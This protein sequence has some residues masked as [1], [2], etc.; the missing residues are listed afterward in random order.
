[1]LMA[2]RIV[3][4]L[5]TVLM[6][7]PSTRLVVAAFKR[8]EPPMAVIKEAVIYIVILVVIRWLYRKCSEERR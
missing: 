1:M 8:S 2:A 4:T 7:W 6:L 5:L 3:L